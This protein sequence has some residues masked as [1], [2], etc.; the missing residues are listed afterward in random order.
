LGPFIFIH[1]ICL[2]SL[3]CRLIWTAMQMEQTA[4]KD[5]SRRLDN[6]FDGALVIRKLP[7]PIIEVIF[8][9]LNL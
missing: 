3:V 4:W 1:G 5:D 9:S 7:L 6:A 2:L 8:F